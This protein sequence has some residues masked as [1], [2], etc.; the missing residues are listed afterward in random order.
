MVKRVGKIEITKYPKCEKTT[1]QHKIGKTK[2]V[3][4]RFRCYFYGGSYTPEKKQQG[5]SA[6]IRQ[7]A[8]HFYVDGMGLRRMGRQLGVPR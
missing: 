6:N 3:S 8:T 5:Y 4:Q 7:K 1:H 2:A